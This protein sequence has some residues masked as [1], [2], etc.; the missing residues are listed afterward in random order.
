MPMCAFAVPHD[1]HSAT[2]PET[3][4]SPQDLRRRWVSPSKSMPLKM[5]SSCVSCLTASCFTAAPRALTLSLCAAASAAEVPAVRPLVYALCLLQRSVG[6][7][8]RLLCRHV[9]LPR[10]QTAWAWGA[11]SAPG[12]LWRPAAPDCAPSRA[13]TAAPGVEKG[14]LPSGAQWRGWDE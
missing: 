12:P 11:A 5:G 9:W 14:Q 2:R 10:L 8:S 3:A 6:C 7:G 1:A 13:S 4:Q